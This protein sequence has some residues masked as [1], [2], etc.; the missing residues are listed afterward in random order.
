[1]AALA[2]YFSSP[3]CWHY[4]HPAASGCLLEPALPFPATPDIHGHSAPVNVE[5][6]LCGNP[7]LAANR[8]SVKPAIGAL[9]AIGLVLI[10]WM[11]RLRERSQWRP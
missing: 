6:D 2:G 9:L 10:E 11:L 4:G 5:W 8:R 3:P 1:M 7:G